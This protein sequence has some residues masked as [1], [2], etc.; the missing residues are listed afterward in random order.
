MKISSD[1][2][3]LRDMLQPTMDNTYEEDYIVMSDFLRGGMTYDKGT[4]SITWTARASG[5]SYG[6]Y[7]HV[8]FPLSKDMSPEERELVPEMCK[9]VSDEM[10]NF[11]GD[12]PNSIRDVDHGFLVAADDILSYLTDSDG[13]FQALAVHTEQSMHNFIGH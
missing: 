3:Q 7:D 6:Q 11:K 1:F 2:S 13:L 8:T 10:A 9:L 5:S 4:H 12:I